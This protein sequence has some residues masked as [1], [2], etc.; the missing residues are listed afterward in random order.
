MTQSSKPIELDLIRSNPK[1][2]I[3]APLRW[4]GRVPY[5]VDRYYDFLVY[6]TDPNELDKN[7]KDLVT[8]MDAMQKSDSE[9]MA[10]CHEIWNEIHGDQQCMDTYWST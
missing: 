7:N 6:D 9:K 5:P 1:P 10:K 4:S 2:N 8:Y 3:E